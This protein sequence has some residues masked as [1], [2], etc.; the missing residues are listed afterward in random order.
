MYNEKAL[1]SIQTWLPGFSAMYQYTTIEMASIVGGLLILSKSS[2]EKI[3]NHKLS[4]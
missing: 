4:I 2:L 3:N 1:N